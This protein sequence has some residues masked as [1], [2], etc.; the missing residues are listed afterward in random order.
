FG[1]FVMAVVSSSGKLRVSARSLR[2]LAG[3]TVALLLVLWAASQTKAGTAMVERAGT[4]L[5]SGTL[6]YSDD[7]NAKFRLVAWFEAFQRFSANPVL[8]EAY[9]IPFT[10]EFDAG[11]ARPHNTYLTVLYK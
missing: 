7:P 3:I 6:N 2:L 11:D 1:V 9:G 10:F 8:G 5:V 4:E